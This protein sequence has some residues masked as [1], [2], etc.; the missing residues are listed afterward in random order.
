MPREEALN[1]PLLCYTDSKGPTKEPLYL[2]SSHFA[3]YIFEHILDLDILLKG[4]A[5]TIVMNW[6]S[7]IMEKMEHVFYFSPKIS[8]LS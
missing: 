3:Q 7:K 2:Y 4:I 5:T 1:E 6:V 8:F